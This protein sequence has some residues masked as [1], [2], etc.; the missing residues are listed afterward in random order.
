MNEK[1]QVLVLAL[2]TVGL[3]LVNTIVIISGSQIFSQNAN[4][5]VQ[6]EQAINLAEAGVDKAIT[7]LNMTGG[8]YLGEETTFGP[9][10]FSVTISSPNPNTKVVES[11]SY[12]P[13][14]SNPK[15]KRTIKV[16]VSKGVGVSFNYGIQVGDGGLQMKENSKVIGSIYS[17][18][19]VIMDNNAR[20]T[21][22]AYVA[23]GTVPTPDQEN[24]CI[25]PNCVDFIFGKSVGSDNRLDVA[26]SFK[27][28]SSNYLSKIALKLK[29]IGSP[30][31]VT[32]R[33]LSDE[34]GQPDKNEV[35]ATGTLT[36]NL[37]SSQY[38]FV[39]VAFTNSPYLAEEITY[40]IMLDTSS[41]S[42]N[43][44]SWSADSLQSYSRGS[45][46]WS[47]NWKANNP[48]W[49]STSSPPVD[50]DFKTYVGGIITYIEGSNGVI[51]GGDAHA[52]TLKDL[53]ITGGAYYQVLDNVTAA[54]YHNSP[55]PPV[56]I[57]P[58]S[59]ANI[60]NWKNKA[61]EEGVYTGDITS[62][63]SQLGPGK[64]IGNV[65]FLNTCTITVVDPVWITGNLTLANGIILKLP[66]SYGASSGV[67]INDGQIELSNNGR[68]QGSGEVG[69]FLMLLSTYDSR[70][71]GSEAIDV[72]NG[73]DESILYAPSGIIKIE[74]NNSL[75]ELAAWK[76]ELSNGVIIDY[77]QGLSGS[78]FSSGPSG[79]YTWVKGTYQLK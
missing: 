43:Y 20:I 4:Y 77:D 50:L 41:D 29:K 32:V 30:S 11:T 75:N 31:D 58:I 21:G 48:A 68:I 56:K 3:V 57:M 69:S 28:D 33:I 6:V 63:T 8:S 1:G 46:K 15:V 79:S 55:D 2:V 45:S 17:N 7:S 10:V 13:S 16:N 35:L 71:T 39:E 74:N 26:Q 22:D 44:W 23:G 54:S 53:T 60:T 59:E 67:I 78:F 24:E 19:N 70:V 51:I 37:V 72:K 42:S 9:G 73:G 38:G 66:V 5:S 61:Q 47:S 64:Y 14:K 27:P 76:I 65:Y 40:W 25:S 18:G 52:N 12:I 36:A 49:I 34:N 62:C